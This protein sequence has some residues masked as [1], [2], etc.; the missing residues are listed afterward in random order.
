MINITICDDETIER[1][2]LKKLVHGWA[3]EQGHFLCVKTFESGESFL[4]DY[5]EN[6]EVDILLL[7]IQMKEIDGVS[8]A[9]KLR[10]TNSEVQIIFITGITEFISEGYEVSA[11]HYLLKPVKEEKL[12]EVLTK[13]V[14][15]LGQADKSMVLNI[16]K[17]N[18][19]ITLKDIKYI[20]SADHYII[21][22]TIDNIYKLK[23]SLGDIEKK[24]DK[25][26]I[27]CQRSFIIGLN[28]IKKTTKSSVFLEGNI[29]IPISRG[30]YKTI[31]E[32]IIKY[33]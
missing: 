21:I 16:N 19:I 33:L 7:D 17:E 22:N 12:F 13:A 23:M 4:F 2:Y 28:H 9:K 27:R 6:K 29:E 15:K 25:S 8:L 11:L 1:R 31:N 14:E 26:F 18:V 20:E 5:E 32:V 24:L 30:M 3:K 10:E